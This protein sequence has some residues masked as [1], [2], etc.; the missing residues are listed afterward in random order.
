[1]LRV[2]DAA[3]LPLSP[4]PGWGAGLSS[5]GGRPIAALPIGDPALGPGNGRPEWSRRLLGRSRPAKR[6]SARSLSTRLSFFAVEPDP[7]LWRRLSVGRRCRSHRTNAPSFTPVPTPRKKI[8]PANTSSPS[9]E[10]WCR[11]WDVVQ[12]DW[13]RTRRPIFPHPETTLFQVAG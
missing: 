10:P 7:T 4:R 9:L 13:S 8:P 5:V 3:T 12:S 1:M 2:L 11:L 6:G